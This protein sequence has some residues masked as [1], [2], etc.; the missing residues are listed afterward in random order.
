MGT[1]GSSG[2]VY[3]RQFLGHT[4]KEGG[5]KELL[6]MLGIAYFELPYGLFVVIHRQLFVIDGDKIYLV[7]AKRGFAQ[8]VAKP[9]REILT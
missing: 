7:H 4:I 5:E 9:V 8:D 2:E 6:R 1:V 3:M